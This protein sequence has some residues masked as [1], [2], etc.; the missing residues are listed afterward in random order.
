MPKPNH[1]RGQRPGKRENMKKRKEGD[2]RAFP[3]SQPLIFRAR[4]NSITMTRDIRKQKKGGEQEP[5]EKKQ[6]KQKKVWRG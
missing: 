5:Q 4:R 1:R 6:T 3:R 2:E